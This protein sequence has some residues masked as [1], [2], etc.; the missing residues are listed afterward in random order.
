MK[1]YNAAN[2]SAHKTVGVLSWV[3][4]PVFDTHKAHLQQNSSAASAI[5]GFSWCMRRAPRLRISQIHHDSL[6]KVQLL[7]NKASPSSEAKWFLG[8]FHKLFP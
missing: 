3:G 1:I 5:Q 8:E 7:L 6:L 4:F 2:Y